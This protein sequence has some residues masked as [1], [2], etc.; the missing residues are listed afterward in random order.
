[1]Q[2]F[3]LGYII[4]SIC[5]IFTVGGFPLDSNVRIA[6]TA[7]HI[8]AITATTW[9][10]LLNGVVGFQWL[11]DGTLFSIGLILASAI[12][13]FIGSGYLVLDTAHSWTHHFDDSLV[14]PN[15]N[16]GIYVLYQLVPLIFLVFYF[17]LETYLVVKV[18]GELRPMSMSTLHEPLS[19]EHN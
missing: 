6:F 9:V 10:L 13:M 7:I 12:V 14:F 5:E 15:R 18:L 1:M 8:G 4:I 2:L 3:L 19:P 17:L 11:D 16:I